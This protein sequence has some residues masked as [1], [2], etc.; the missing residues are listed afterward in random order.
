MPQSITCPSCRKAVPLRK[1][2]EPP[3]SCPACGA[4]LVEDA[5]EITPA[6]SARKKREDQITEGAAVESAPR[7]RKLRCPACDEEISRDDRRCPACGER[8]L[9]ADR[10]VNV[11]RGPRWAPCPSCGSTHADRVLWTFWGSFYGPAMLSHVRCRPCGQAYNG[12]TGRSNAVWATFFV[13]VPLTLILGILGAVA[14]CII[15][16]SMK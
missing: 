5:T 9:G 12:K 3:E 16:T 13:L 1:N 10:D 8:L 14:W 6:A 4:E 11:R 2:G 7:R 15:S